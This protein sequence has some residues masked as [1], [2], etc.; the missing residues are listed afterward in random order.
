M[1]LSTSL[2]H[3]EAVYKRAG[4]HT[5]SSE[6]ERNERG[7]TRFVGLGARFRDLLGSGERARTAESAM[8]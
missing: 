3:R 4:V 8:D 1:L 7:S 5:I 6:D 2:A